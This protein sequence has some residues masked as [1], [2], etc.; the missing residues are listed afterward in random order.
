MTT[1]IEPL[2]G[3]FFHSADFVGKLISKV[4]HRTFGTP[5]NAPTH[6]GI[7]VTRDLFTKCY[8][9]NDKISYLDLLKIQ[10]DSLLPEVPVEV[11]YME[12]GRFY[13]FE[14]TESGSIS[15]GVYNVLGESKFGPQIRD[16]EHIMKN[17]D[18]KKKNYVSIAPSFNNL[19]RYSKTLNEKDKLDIQ[20][21]VSELFVICFNKHI[22][23]SY[24]TM[25]P[26]ILSTTSSCILKIRDFISSM[27]CIKCVGNI[28]N[29]KKTFCSELVTY[30]L[31]DLHMCAPDIQAYT[32]SPV[33]LFGA[34]SNGE[35]QIGGSVFSTPV[36][37]KSLNSCEFLLEI[38]NSM[39]LK[40][41]SYPVKSKP[42]MDL[43]E[44][45]KFY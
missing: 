17:Y 4:Q 13:V 5:K 2:D 3:V 11:N 32:I 23:D 7:L 43:D 42:N 33:E 24:E 41:I 15:D 14:S 12:P 38:R 1:N 20:Q 30:V 6:C 37:T 26:C 10:K 18:K 40:E 34:K 19:W 27:C 45:L 39:F 29:R 31:R 16:L 35:S 8:S 25:I 36:V 28:V 21:K 22:G 9:D 44:V